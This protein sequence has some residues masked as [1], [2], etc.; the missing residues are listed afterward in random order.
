MVG[1]P[2]SKNNEDIFSGV[3]SIPACDR[4]T[5]ILNDLPYDIRDCSSVSVFKRKL[6]SDLFSIAYIA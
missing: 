1:L 6:K 4:R 3:D 5:D 2:D